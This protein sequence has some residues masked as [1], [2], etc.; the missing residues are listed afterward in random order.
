MIGPTHEGGHTLDLVITRQYDQVIKSAPLIDRFISDHAAVLCQLD[1]VKPCTATKEISYRQLK[2]IDMDAL[3]SDLI[4]S[5]LCTSVFTDLDMMVS[6]YNSTLSSLLDKY[7]P[8]RTKS[9]ANGK[10]GPWFNHIIKDAIKARRRAERKWRYFK[11]AQDLSV[12]KKKKNHAIYLMNQARCDY[13]TNHIQQNSSDQRKL[14]NVTKSLLCDTNTASFPRVDNVRLANDF[15]NFFAQKIE[16]INASLANSSTSSVPS[17]PATDITC[18]K[19][20][21]TG[22]KTLSQEQ[23]R[24]LISKAAGKSCQ[25]DPIPTPIVLKLLDVLLPVI[26]KLINLSFDTGRFAEAWKEAL[27]LPS[28]KKPGLD[29]AFKNSRPVSNLSYISKLSER[30]GVEQF[31]EHDCQRFTFSASISV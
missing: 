9:V 13:Y 27:V 26:T 19:E 15:G 28:L 8:L 11:S 17:L 2:S 24:M 6:Y 5:E 14:F 25:L 22:F 21:F 16:N 3:S 1:S 31:M 10:R 12:F 18:L 4:A 30:A 7:A 20:R 29:S 23:V